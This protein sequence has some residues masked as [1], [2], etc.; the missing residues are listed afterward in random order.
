MKSILPEKIL[1]IQNKNCKLCSLYK[2][3]QSVCLMGNG[4]IN[5]PVIL[6]GEAPGLRE[7]DINKPF[8]GKSG[9]LLDSALNQLG[10]NRDS[11]FITN[12]VKCRPPENT[13]PTPE[14]QF[15]CFSYL[16]KEIKLI[17]PKVIITLGSIAG[18]ILNSNLVSIQKEH[19]KFFY[20][21]K[22]KCLG[23]C[24]FHPAFI[25]RRAS[26]EAFA[27]FKFELKKGFYK[28]GLI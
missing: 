22:Y 16:D 3:A 23:I 19:G 15:K 6:I 21:S 14:Q 8:S 18:K 9:K 11:I 26:A 13:T 28:G 7:E 25:L 24:T 10:I 27:I 12:A 20:S 1:K 17:K 5:S 4:S 2:T